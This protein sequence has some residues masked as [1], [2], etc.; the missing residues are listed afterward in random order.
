MKKFRRNKKHIHKYVLYNTY[1]FA[2]P[3]IYIVVYVTLFSYWENTLCSTFGA[4]KVLLLKAYQAK[5]TPDINYI[6]MFFLIAIFA[7]W[8][9]V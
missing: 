4:Q 3:S 5:Y 7:S 9:N 8:D 2:F 1:A 6:I